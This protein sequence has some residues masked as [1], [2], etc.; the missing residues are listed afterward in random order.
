MP[1]PSNQGPDKRIYEEYTGGHTSY[2]D[3]PSPARVE[4]RPAT[5]AAAG[6]ASE[7]TA[8]RKKSSMTSMIVT[9][10]LIALA[11][12]LIMSMMGMCSKQPATTYTGNSPSESNQNATGSGNTGQASAPQE[13]TPIQ[14]S[15]M[16]DHF[17]DTASAKSATVM[18]YMCGSDLETYNS[19][20]SKDIQ[21]MVNAQLGDNVK[22]VL[23][24]GGSRQWHFTNMAD[25]RTRQR[26]LIDNSGMYLVDDAGAG[27]MLNQAS[28]TDFVNWSV[29]N[30]PAD[31]YLFVFWDHGGGTIGGFGSDEMYPNE[32]PLTLLELR[33]ALSNS[34][35]KMDLVGFDACLMGTIECAYAM[36]PCADY[37]L[38]SEE[39]E[40]GDGWMWTGLLTALGQNP[41]IDTVELGKVAIDDFTNYYFNQRLTDITLSLVDLREVPYV[42]EQMGEFLTKAEQTISNDNNRFVEMSQARTKARS[43][44]DGGLDQ[45]DVTDLIARTNFDGKDELMA[46]VNSC[47]KYRSGTTISGA[48]GLAM[49]FPYSEVRSYQGTRSILNG[50]GYV[51]PTEFYDY[52]LSIMG[53]SPSS[54]S[55]NGLIPLWSNTYSQQGSAASGSA[56]SWTFANSTFSGEDWFEQLFGTFNYQPVPDQLSFNYQDGGYVVDMNDGMWNVFSSFQTTV[57]EE[58]NGGFLMLGRDDVYDQTTGGDIIVF[59]NNEWLTIQGVPVS[60][61]SNEPQEEANGEYS[62]SGIIPALLNGETYIEIS[63]YWPPRSQQTG[64][65]T[66]IIQGYRMKNGGFLTIGRGL[67]PFQAGDTITPLFD[68]YDGSGNYVQTELGNPITVQDPD[69]LTVNY[70]LFDHN[71]VHF[72]GTM[73]TV[74]GDQIDTSVIVQ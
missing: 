30:Y 26:W 2:G 56:S 27:T 70:E 67:I 72:W 6:G 43:F 32:D 62:H 47:V 17:V 11:A 53:G 21:E 50:I 65:Y 54:S 16:R 38:A 31:R 23:Q 44:A 12:L 25:P 68:F 59:Y 39:Y 1:E 4:E 46:A 28:V 64:A 3:M 49:Y 40:M 48:N 13:G 45:V 14:A 8:T 22:V 37:L 41:A 71:T 9:I 7:G 10:G 15:G 24:T 51:K 57:M 18:V 66:G 36:E 42:Y 34:G 73:T 35:Q 20:A 58:Y 19:A 60:F 69:N 74:Y 55:S 29:Q 5:A 33:T 63:V 52:F 61:F